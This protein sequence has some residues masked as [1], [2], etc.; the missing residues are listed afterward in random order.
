MM[1]YLVVFIGAGVGG[2]IRHGMNIW[3]ARLLGTHFPSHT[4]IINIVGSLVMGLVAGWFAERGGAAGHTRLFLTTGILGLMG[5][6]LQI[7]PI[8]QLGPYKPSQVSAGSQPDF[9]MMWT[10]GLARLWPAWEF[11]PFGHTIPAAVAV[12]LIMGLVFI[13]LTIYPFLEKKFSGDDVHHNLLQRPRLVLDLLLQ[14]HDGVNQLFRPRRAARHVH[15]DGNHLVD[16][17]QRVVVEHAGRG[18][19]GPHGDDPLGLGHLLVEVANHRRHLVADASGDDH[20]IRLA[21]RPAE[22]FRAEAGDIEAR[23]GH[24]HHLDG[25]A[26]QAE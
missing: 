19:A 26:G 20:Q 18:G 13:L 7:N 8:W 25:A 10:E 21:R 17:D 4:F 5:G 23:G 2:S 15:I 12:A 3:V 11:Y 24:R 14:H 9:Y 16:G 1:S 6:L 22:H